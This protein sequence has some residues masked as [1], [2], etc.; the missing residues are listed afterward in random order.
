M[1]MLNTDMKPLEVRFYTLGWERE[2]LYT[3]MQVVNTYCPDCNA[4]QAT[5]FLTVLCMKRIYII[6]VVSM[7]HN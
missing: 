2:I 4:L 7:K 1:A 3:S 6:E 5:C